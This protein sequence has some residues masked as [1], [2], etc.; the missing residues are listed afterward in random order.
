MVF[1]NLSSQNSGP[2]ICFQSV[3]SLK[4]SDEYG[5]NLPIKIRSRVMAA[6]NDLGDHSSIEARDNLTRKVAIG[7]AGV[8]SELITYKIMTGDDNNGGG[9]DCQV[10]YGMERQELR[11]S[12][13]QVLHLRRELGDTRAEMQRQDMQFKH[14]LSHINT[15]VAR[16]AAAAAR[17]TVSSTEN[18]V[19][20]QSN[21]PEAMGKPGQPPR[22]LVTSLSE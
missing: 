11:L 12:S 6:Y 19:E 1:S 10:R 7:M 4:I 9:G 15:N 22:H 2:V 14:S 8:D 13:S 21:R 5:E 18:G 3:Q 17:H 20:G 16:L